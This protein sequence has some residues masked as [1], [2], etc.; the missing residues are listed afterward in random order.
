MDSE[1]TDRSDRIPAGAEWSGTDGPLVQAAADPL[2]LV[3]FTLNGDL[4]ALAGADV[5]ELLPYETVTFVPGSPDAIEGIINLRGE[6]ESVLDLHRILGLAPSEPTPHGRIVMAARDGVRSGIRVDSVV[7]VVSVAAGAVKRPL[8][9]LD[10]NVRAYAAGGETL[11]DGR[12]VTLLD[13]GKLFAGIA[14]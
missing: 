11:Y 7:D 13:T 3:I 8:S 12:Y 10:P 6:I 2:D 14:P 4:Y 5:R 9:T 1:G